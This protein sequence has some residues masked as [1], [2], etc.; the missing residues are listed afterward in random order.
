MVI[1]IV[2]AGCGSQIS[3]T[4]LCICGVASKKFELSAD[5][6][7]KTNSRVTIVLSG[8]QIPGTRVPDIQLNV[9]GKKYNFIYLHI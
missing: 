2:I 5:Y 3:T 8:I 1:D 9:M 4:L 7:Q 6:S